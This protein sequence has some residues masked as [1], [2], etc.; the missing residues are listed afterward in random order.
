MTGRH[1]EFYTKYVESILSMP[2]FCRWSYRCIGNLSK[3]TEVARNYSEEQEALGKFDAVIFSESEPMK[4]TGT[5]QLKAFGLDFTLSKN[6]KIFFAEANSD[7][8]ECWKNNK[9]EVKDAGFWL[10]KTTDENDNTRVVWMV[11]TK[12]DGE[13]VPVKEDN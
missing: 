11:F 4:F 3:Q 13:T 12:S 1:Q 10:Q 9:Q 5:H 6:R 7:F 2:D 8:W